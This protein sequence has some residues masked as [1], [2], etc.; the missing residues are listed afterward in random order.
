MGLALQ[1]CLG[2]S[3]QGFHVTFQSLNHFRFSV[4]NKHVGFLIY[5]IRRF[6]GN[7]FDVYFHL[8]RNGTPNWEHEK[9]LWE[10]EQA[11]EWTTVL[12]KKSKKALRQSAHKRPMK[13]VRFADN[14]VM[15]S[16][17]IKHA[18]ASSLE[19]IVFGS[20]P[21]VQ[22]VSAKSAASDVLGD[23]ADIPA[24]RVFGRVSSDLNPKMFTAKNKAANQGFSK[25]QNSELVSCAHCL[26][27]GH[28]ALEC[29]SPIRCR[30]CF[31]Y[32]HQASFCRTMSKPRIYWKPK[33]IA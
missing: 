17:R 32:G 20:F 23:H 21:P 16:P 31:F 2:G 15:D 22:C 25:F 24:S 9:R 26:G 1:S 18:P 6:I 12:S 30:L 13:R 29:L 14:L 3:A 4:V 27:L 8:W 7:S 10:E 5:N 33:P 19:T 11:K 28:R